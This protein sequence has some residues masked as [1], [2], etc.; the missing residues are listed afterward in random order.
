MDLIHHSTLIEQ[1]KK[2]KKQKTHTIISTDTKK[3]F[4]K[5]QRT[6]FQDKKISKLGIQGNF[7]STIKGIYEKSTTNTLLDGERLKV[8]SL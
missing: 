4:D 8:F 2:N 6:T 3:A 7:L 1:R 5:I